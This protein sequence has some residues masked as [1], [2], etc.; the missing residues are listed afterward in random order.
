MINGVVQI[1]LAVINEQI[2]KLSRAPRLGR[3]LSDA[4][5]DSE[6]LILL[7]RINDLTIANNAL[8]FEVRQDIERLQLVIDTY[9]DVDTAIGGWSDSNFCS[10]SSSLN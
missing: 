8:E 2:D 9:L 4:L 5:K 10:S 1:L 6:K 7:A 3:T